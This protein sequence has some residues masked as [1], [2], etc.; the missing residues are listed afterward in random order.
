MITST[1]DTPGTLTTASLQ[2][3]TAAPINTEVLSPY[4]PGVSYV[5]QYS[6]TAPTQLITSAIWHLS[7][8]NTP[9]IRLTWTPAAPSFSS[10]ALTNYSVLVGPNPT[11]RATSLDLHDPNLEPVANPTA[12]QT[13]IDI[14]I[15]ANIERVIYI[16]IWPIYGSTYR[17]TPLFR[18]T[19]SP[20][21]GIATQVVHAETVQID[22]PTNLQVIDIPPTTYQA[23]FLNG[24]NLY[25]I[26]WFKPQNVPINRTEVVVNG[27]TIITLNKDEEARIN[28]INSYRRS[29]IS[30]VRVRRIPGQNTISIVV[31]GD[32]GTVSRLGP[33]PF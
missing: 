19:G 11:T 17:V 1:Y 2:V 29:P 12:T 21:P 10:V 9:F 20:L 4:D 7:A 23:S 30:L 14:R 26:S 8:D 13:T 15:G 32:N 25:D 28:W 18:I 3:T 22:P 16:T 27:G 5:P 6:V 31:Y 24:D 33:L